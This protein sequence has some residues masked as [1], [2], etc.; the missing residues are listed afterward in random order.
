MDLDI[1]LAGQ[2]AAAEHLDVDAL[3]H[4]AGGGERIGRDSTGLEP[5]GELLEGV[6]V[7]T[8]VLD[9]EGLE[10]RHTVEGQAMRAT[11]PE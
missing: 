3:A 2:L 7:D 5:V 6:E 11:R 1:E 8:G 4:G 9:A 10:C